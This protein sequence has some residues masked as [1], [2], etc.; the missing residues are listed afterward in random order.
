MAAR[1]AGSLLHALGLPE[2]V[3]PSLAD[4]E[5]LVVALAQDPARVSAL[6]ARVAGN[7]KTHPLFDTDRFRRHVEAAYVAMYERAQ[8]GEPPAAFA[9]NTSSDA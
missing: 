1:M 2:L 8:R 5:T 3:T 9:V 7:R 4:Y 6:K